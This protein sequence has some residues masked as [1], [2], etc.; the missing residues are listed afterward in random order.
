MVDYLHLIN[1][2]RDEMHSSD[3][4]KAAQLKAQEPQVA[5]DKLESRE[6]REALVTMGRYSAFTAPVMVSLLV[7][8]PTE[9]FAGSGAGETRPTRRRRGRRMRM[10]R[11]WRRYRRNRINR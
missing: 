7:A 1:K 4:Q 11:R 2:L 10:F 9:A 6:R 3:E 5:E 8:K